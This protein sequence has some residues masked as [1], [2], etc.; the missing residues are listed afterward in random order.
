MR[1]LRGHS[2]QVQ[3]VGW[4]PD[5]NRIATGSYDR[6]VKVW[7]AATGQET[8]TLRGHTATVREVHWHPTGCR[9]VT[10]D[11]HGN[12]LTWDA[13]PSYLGERSATT[14]RELGE[15]IKRD[16]A[17]TRAR[18]LRAE[19]LARRGDQNAAAD[20]WQLAQHP[21]SA[22]VVYPESWWVVASPEDRPPHFPSDTNARWLAPADDPNGFVPLP[23][24]GTTAVCRFFAPRPA[25]V[26]LEVG[27]SAP[28]RLWL[29]EK[30]ITVAGMAPT[31]VE[32]REGWN[33]LAV[34]G[35]PG[36]LYVRW[37]DLDVA[38]P[39]TKAGEKK[40]HEVAPPPRQR[41]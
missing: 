32:V 17:D 5:G 13:M 39:R 20:Y 15:R 31:L 19:V 18:R 34:R 23:E 24:G 22:A 35:G 11:D 3:S 25:K 8:L 7:D 28:G 29:N 40:S 4:S 6:T 21:E 26:A 14:L 33:T 38:A 27:P 9:L 36:E 12:V 30:A 1:T 2:G 37:G 16:P 41:K 10:R